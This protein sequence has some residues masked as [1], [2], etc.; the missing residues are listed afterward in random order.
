[1]NKNHNSFL[2]LLKYIFAL[3]IAFYHNQLIIENNIVFANGRYLTA[4]YFL[5]SG[6]FLLKSFNKYEGENTFKSIFKF[7]WYKLRSIGLPL[8]LGYIASVLYSFLFEGNVL[9]RGVLHY[10]WFIHILIICETLLFILFRIC[11]TKKIYYAFVISILVIGLILKFIEPFK[12]LSETDAFIYIPLGNLLGM[13]NLKLNI[14]KP[15]VITIFILSL[16][17]T[18]ISLFFLEDNIV[19]ELIL[20]ILILPILIISTLNIN[21]NI[22]FFNFLGSLS[23]SIYVCQPIIVLIR[24][25]YPSINQIIVGLLLMVIVYILYIIKAYYN[26]FKNLKQKKESL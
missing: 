15:I 22:P 7:I 8:L 16:V 14:K 17:A 11:K 5:I 10:L 18:I 23:A 2:D 25:I 6:I 24:Y 3:L 26:Y 12:S 20:K 1:M 13:F 19:N 4:F 9:T 21:V